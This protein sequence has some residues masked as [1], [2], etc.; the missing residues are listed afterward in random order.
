[1]KCFKFIMLAIIMAANFFIFGIVLNGHYSKIII[2]DFS[3][4]GENANIIIYNFLMMIV[5][6]LGDYYI[7]KCMKEREDR[8]KEKN[9]NKQ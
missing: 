2:Y 8:Q 9:K 7:L 4:F 6:V 1:M 5:V 3:S